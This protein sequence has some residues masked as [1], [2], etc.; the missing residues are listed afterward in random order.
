MPVARAPQQGSSKIKAG[1]N[2]ERV[3]ECPAAHSA[4][5]EPPR[6]LDRSCSLIIRAPP[7]RASHV[8]RGGRACRVAKGRIMRGRPQRHRSPVLRALAAWPFPRRAPGPGL[9]PRWQL[10]SQPRALPPLMGCSA[11]AHDPCPTAQSS[12]FGVITTYHPLPL[13]LSLYSSPHSHRSSLSSRSAPLGALPSLPLHSLLPSGFLLLWVSPTQLPH[14]LPH[15]ASRGLSYADSISFVPVCTTPAPAPSSPPRCGNAESDNLP[16]P[17][18]TPIREEERAGG[19]G[20]T[21]L[22]GPGT[23]PGDGGVGIGAQSSL[24]D[25]AGSHVLQALRTHV[26]GTRGHGSPLVRAHGTLMLFRTGKA[27]GDELPIRHQRSPDVVIECPV[28]G[29]EDHL[30]RALSDRITLSGSQFP[31][32]DGDLYLCRAD[33]IRPGAPSR[34]DRSPQLS[35][36]ESKRASASKLHDLA[37]H[38]SRHLDKLPLN[39]QKRG[40]W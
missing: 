28:A 5:S 40:A 11:I 12:L 1:A 21:E 16:D 4:Y 9:V 15:L 8:P 17:G 27:G 18:S 24:A 37:D 26:A 19:E 22:P 29:G 34:R 23:V 33:C 38:V 25:A 3:G 10:V 13:P 30:A 36:A 6:P 14:L 39:A 31:F 20:R 2:H 35:T 32:L 7:S